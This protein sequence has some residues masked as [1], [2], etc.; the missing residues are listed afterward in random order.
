MFCNSLRR[1]N[2][3]TTLRDLRPL[4]LSKLWWGVIFIILFQLT[5]SNF[6]LIIII[7]TQCSHESIFLLFIMHNKTPLNLIHAPLWTSNQPLL[8]TMVRFK[9]KYFT[10]PSEWYNHYST[11]RQIHFLSLYYRFFLTHIF[12]L[13]QI[14]PNICRV[15]AWHTHINS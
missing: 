6:H 8:D 10:L 11:S 2:L 14:L 12:W 7:V 1:R 3:L 15:T 9:F 5:H 13:S 4:R